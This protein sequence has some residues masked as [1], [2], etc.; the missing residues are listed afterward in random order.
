MVGKEHRNA[1]KPQGIHDTRAPRF[2]PTSTKTKFTCFQSPTT[3]KLIV[4]AAMRPSSPDVVLVRHKPRHQVK[5]RIC[6]VVAVDQWSDRTP[7]TG[8]KLWVNGS[9]WET[10]GREGL[11]LNWL[12][13]NV[14]NGEI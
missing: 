5:I 10:E 8:D 6:L 1:T 13:H 9:S 12:V 7:K 11:G 3:A 4:K 14:V 2:L